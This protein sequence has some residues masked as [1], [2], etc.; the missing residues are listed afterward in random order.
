MISE[1]GNRRIMSNPKAKLFCVLSA[2]SLVISG[3]LPAFAQET[4][5]GAAAGKVYDIA[6][7]QGIGGARVQVTNK[8]TGSQRYFTTRSDGSYT[9]TALISGIYTISASSPDYENIPNS[10]LSTVAEF[11]V[12]LAKT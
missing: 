7:T 12:D 4:T 3:T 2:L 1:N 8:E 6:N 10:P 5:S 9:A 11:R